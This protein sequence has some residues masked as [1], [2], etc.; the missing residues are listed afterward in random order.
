M[1]SKEAF[2]LLGQMLSYPS[3]RLASAAERCAGLLATEH[4]AAVDCL[5]PFL[6][7]L[8][9]TSLERLEEVYTATFDL[10]PVCC[11]YAAYHLFGD[12][13]KRSA[14]MLKLLEAY[15][16]RAFSA[17]NELP[18]HVALLLSFLPR[19]EGEPEND[20]RREV[21]IPAL[22]KMA[23]S[24]D[25]RNPYHSVISAALLLVQGE[26]QARPEGGV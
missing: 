12:G 11:P 4:A 23:S 2:P 1:V 13:P 21:L 5:A 19:L 25:T 15:R 3:P 7:W 16:E 9:N 8:G 6:S 14:L 22:Q 17:G 18:D 20:L 26:S 24:L 10:N